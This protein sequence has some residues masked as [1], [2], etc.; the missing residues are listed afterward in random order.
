MRSRLHARIRSRVRPRLGGIGAAYLDPATLAFQSATGASDLAGVDAVVRYLKAESLFNSAMFLPLKSAQNYGTGALAHVIGGL[1]SG[2]FTINNGAPWAGDGVA[3]NG[4]NQFLAKADFLGDGDFVVL[5]GYSSATESDAVHNT[6]F[7]QWE[8]TTN[9][10]SIWLRMDDESPISAFR[11]S[12]GAGNS[13]NYG[14]TTGG[15]ISGANVAYRAIDGGGRDIWI[16]GAK[17][18]LS[19]IGSSTD[20]TSR[21]NSS[22]SVAI[23]AINADSGASRL[24]AATIKHCLV[25]DGSSVS[26]S[27]I[28]TLTSLT[29][30]L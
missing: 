29:D 22:A 1:T 30:A 24:A 25:I 20:Q 6:L 4:S 9:D 26:D 5:I 13:E 2:D 27:N 14:I 19:L 11:D 16:N 8:G 17:Q 3:L 23:G 21:H 10:R 28:E 15:F 7:S 12:S 18:T